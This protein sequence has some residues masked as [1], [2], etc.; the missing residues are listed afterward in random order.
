MDTYI[1]EFPINKTL[2]LNIN[3][4]DV[5]YDK[6]VLIIQEIKKRNFKD[7]NLSYSL[8]EVFIIKILDTLQGEKTQEELLVV[9]K[10]NHSLKNLAF[11]APELVTEIWNMVTCEVIKIFNKERELILSTFYD[12]AF[13][14][15]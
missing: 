6:K 1:N 11:R 2:K 13:N 8:I 5:D 12:Y 10:L 9:R 14:S 15:C 3:Y 7:K 4:T